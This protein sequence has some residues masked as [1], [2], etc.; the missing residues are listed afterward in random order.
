MRYSQ[1]HSLV[2]TV[3]IHQLI[4]VRVFCQKRMLTLAWPT[5]FMPFPPSA[6]IAPEMGDLYI[7]DYI[8]ACHA[9]FQTDFDGCIRK[10]ITSAENFFTARAWVPKKISCWQQIADK[11]FR[12]P[13]IKSKFRLILHDNLNL[14]VISGDVIYH[15]MVFIYRVRNKIVHAD[16]RTP[17]HARMFCNKALG[18]LK[19]MLLRN[20]GDRRKANYIH[21]LHMQFMMQ[22]HTFG[23]E[24]NLDVIRKRAARPSSPGFIIDSASALEQAMFS[25]LRFD[26]NELKIV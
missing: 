9:Y 15:N 20:C 24:M 18:T 7:R 17:P 11:L 22:C 13:R 2:N 21:H 10:V 1:G 19:Y 4:Q 5:A 8:D 23:E 12:R 6:T 16:F 3:A 26:E 25:S 14:S